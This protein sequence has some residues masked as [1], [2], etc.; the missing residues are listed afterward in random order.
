M[1][2]YFSGVIIYDIDLI[3]DD[4]AGKREFYP[5]MLF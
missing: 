3:V 2:K 5:L 1:L 4:C